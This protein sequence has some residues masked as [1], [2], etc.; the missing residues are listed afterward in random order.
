MVVSAFSRSITG[1][2][3][4]PSAEFGDG[5]VLMH[6]VGNVVHW[7]VR[8]GSDCTLNQ[9]VALGSTSDDGAPPRLVGDRVTVF[10]GAR[11]LGDIYIGDG[12]QIGAN[13][14]VLSDVPA[15]ATAVEV[16]VRILARS[17]TV[18]E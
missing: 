9:Q 12:A 4:P 13:P 5:P 1:I 17:P 14:V 10:A 15:G 7:A 18:A 3:I 16:P 6:G 8:A 11:V 2:E